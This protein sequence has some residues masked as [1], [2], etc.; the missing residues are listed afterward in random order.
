M[1]DD[2]ETRDLALSVMTR[3]FCEWVEWAF[4]VSGFETDDSAELRE[5]I[6]EKIRT[7]ER[8]GYMMALEKVRKVATDPETPL[9][10]Q[11]RYDIAWA[12]ADLLRKAPGEAE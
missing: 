9:G 1:A 10:V 12:A 8:R 6:E 2:N 5:G 4:K 7:A 3:S 11:Q